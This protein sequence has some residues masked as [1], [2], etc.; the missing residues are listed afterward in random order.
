MTS[1]KQQFLKTKHRK[2]MRLAD[3]DYNQP[4]FY[5]ITICTK[6]H[7]CHF[8]NITETQNFLSSPQVNLSEIGKIAKKCWLEI[9]KH[10]PNTKLDEFTIMPN[11]LHGIIEIIDPRI[12]RYRH[13]CTL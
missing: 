7:E 12:V 3:Y 8:A 6:N 1:E 9:P 10:F 4:G 13:A 5:F 2:I 11:H